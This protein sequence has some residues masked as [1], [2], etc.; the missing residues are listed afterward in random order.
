MTVDTMR[1][2]DF[3]AG[4]PLCALS[5][6]I[7]KLFCKS[8]VSEPKN[9]LLIELSE[10]GSTIL[11]DPMMQKLKNAGC[12][13]HF[14]IFKKNKPSLDL[15]KSIPEE[16]IYTINDSGLGNIIK[17]TL[18]F[19]V[20]CRKKNIDSVIDLEL[21]S[22]FTALLT[23]FC[24]AG[25]RVGYH[26]FTQEGLYRGNML[27]KKVAYNSHQHI[28]KNFIALADALLSKEQQTPFT[29]RAVGDDEI[30]LRKISISEN[31][32]DFMRKKMQAQCDKLDF[33]K[34]RVALFNANAS[35]L[36]PLRR[37][38]RK[39]YIEL[40]KRLLAKDENLYI[41]L[42]GALAERD[43]LQFIADAL[44]ERCVNFAG[45]TTFTELPLLYSS[46]IFM[47]T[48]DS[49]PAHF[50]AVTDLPT[51]VIFGPETPK[52]YG[53]LGNFTPIYAGLS[54]SPCV[55]AHNHRKTVCDDN[56]CVK[57]ISV[58][59]VDGVLKGFFDVN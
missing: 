7:H 45:K 18:G 31:E 49:G 9:V 56:Q 53:S 19:L 3:W 24:G 47:L 2:V 57:Q 25:I 44:G 50:A 10:M 37:W 55:S 33:N 41:Y 29:K 1:V 48:N 39:N 51:F 36:M 13:L 46:C 32:K 30:K 22:R 59:Y 40:G 34:H 21:F 5:T 26:A 35:D 6:P 54:C 23:G 20:W 38:G 52:L 17:D 58:D 11:A 27:T 8:G 42:T 15:L 16:N 43:G 12:N 14:V 4:V 28:S